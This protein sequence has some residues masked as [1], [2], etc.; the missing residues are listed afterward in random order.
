M[1]SVQVVYGSWFGGNR[2]SAQVAL[3]RSGW[4]RELE[5]GVRVR[6]L[7]KVSMTLFLYHIF[8]SHLLQWATA[9]VMLVNSSNV[10]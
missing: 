4:E 5:S 9:Q 8:I 7:R 1:L 2:V 10:G 6:V 3:V